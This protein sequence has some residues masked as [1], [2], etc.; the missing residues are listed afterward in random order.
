M[1]LFLHFKI[2]LEQ[3]IAS[4][5]FAWCSYLNVLIVA[6]CQ[7]TS[8]S[9][10]PGAVDGQMFNPF[11]NTAPTLA[12]SV[13]NALI[14]SGDPILAQVQQGRSVANKVI[15]KGY[16]KKIR[17]SDTAEQLAYRVPGVQLVENNLIV[18]Q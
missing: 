9:P 12:Q 15:L 1:V 10:T 18:R 16:V 3:V 8:T 13:Q 11:A 17:Q 7:S 2:L 14:Q 4:N 5:P 6:G